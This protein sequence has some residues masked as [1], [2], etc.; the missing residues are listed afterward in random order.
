VAKEA[1]A[2]ALLQQKQ[3]HLKTNS[4]PTTTTR[5]VGSQAK[6][7]SGKLIHTVSLVHR[8]EANVNRQQP[9]PKRYHTICFQLLSTAKRQEEEDDNN[10]GTQRNH[11]N[12]SMFF[13]ALRD[14]LCCNQLLWGTV[15]LDKRG[16]TS[17]V[18]YKVIRITVRFGTCIAFAFVPV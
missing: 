14:R 18:P 17:A 9:V 15:L 12:Y 2:S 5:V 11:G 10:N 13:V 4:E 3:V 1:R 7:Y 16:I 6:G 8:G